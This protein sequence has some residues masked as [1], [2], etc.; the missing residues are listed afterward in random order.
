MPSSLCTGTLARCSPRGPQYLYGG[1]PYFEGMSVH[2]PSTEKR[3]WN[4]K[5]NGAE[6]AS[7][8]R[9]WWFRVRERRLPSLSYKFNKGALSK[10]M[11]NWG[12]R[13]VK[14][15]EKVIGL[16][17]AVNCKSWQRPTLFDCIIETN[18]HF[19]PLMLRVYVM[20]SS[21]YLSLGRNYLTLRFRQGQQRSTSREILRPI[22][23]PLVA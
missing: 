12:T 11:K 4:S 23:R 9:V 13:L 3:I 16:V 20:T 1:Y 18:S 6:S 19:P 17:R 8:E 10:C 7:L 21:P 2:A 22:L 15:T 14:S 5:D